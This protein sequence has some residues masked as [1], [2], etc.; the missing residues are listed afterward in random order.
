MKRIVI[1]FML[2]PILFLFGCSKVYKWEF[3]KPSSAIKQISIIYIETHLYNTE[4][5]INIPP[6]KLID[7]NQ[8]SEFYEEINKLTMKNMFHMEPL[9]PHG[10]CFLID[11]GNDEYCILSIQGSGFIYYDENSN[12]FINDSV[13]LA[14]NNDE[15]SKLLDKYLEFKK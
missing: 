8:N 7:S 14:F 13:D 2:V 11:Y 10:Y 15:Y 1:I 9:F 3:E 6:V 5:I 12:S 4:E